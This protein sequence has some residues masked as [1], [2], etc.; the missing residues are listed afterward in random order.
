MKEEQ[1]HE[2]TMVGGALDWK[3]NNFLGGNPRLHNKLYN[4]I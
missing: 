2:G 3:V 4:C 1:T